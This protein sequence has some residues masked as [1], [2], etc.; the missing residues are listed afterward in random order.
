MRCKAKQFFVA[1]N[2]AVWTLVCVLFVLPVNGAEMLANGNFE[3]EDNGALSCWK[4]GGTIEKKIP[5]NTNGIKN[6]SGVIYSWDS[7]SHAGGRGSLKMEALEIDGKPGG[8]VTSGKIIARPGAEYTL[9]YWYRG[10][11]LLPFDGQHRD[12]VLVVDVFYQTDA[13]FLG[14]KRDYVPANAKDWARRSVTFKTAI[15][16]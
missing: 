10:E 11:G 5:N 3:L 4:P 8:I 13:K 14:N 9:S 12:C 15:I 2:C 1:A 6:S 7:V 16:S